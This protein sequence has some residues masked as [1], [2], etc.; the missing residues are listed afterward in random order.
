MTTETLAIPP[1]PPLQL[2][3]EHLRILVS[4]LQEHALYMLDPD[5]IVISW[6]GGAQSIKHYR[7]EEVIGQHFAIFFTAEDRA[8][9]HPQ[10]ALGI[11]R[12]GGIME[13]EGWRVRKDGS[14]FW[15]SV[16]ITAMHSPGGELIGFAK[17]TRD[18]SAR[19]TAEL[20]F[21]VALDRT[22]AAERLLLLKNSELEL[23]VLERT[24]ELT[25]RSQD[26]LRSNTELRQFN[27]IASHDLQEPLRLI[28]AFCGKLRESDQQ[29]FT[30]D[31]LEDMRQVIHAAGRMKQLILDLLAFGSVQNRTGT[32]IMMSLDKAVIEARANLR[33][34]ID[35]SQA[36]IES[37]DLPTLTADYR[38]MV[39]LLQNLIGNALKYR[40]D[41]TPLITIQ[42][43][44]HESSWEISVTDNGI[45]I[46]ER[47]RKRVF[48]L[49]KRLHRSDR[50]PGTGL[51]LALCKLIVDLHHGAIRIETPASGMGTSFV[52]TLPDR[53]LDE[54]SIHS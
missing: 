4:S 17:V 35:E 50:Y 18:I 28:S 20:L 21:Q 52:V 40:G 1:T 38:L 43:R 42:G 15:A 5:G 25:I 48:E 33:V 32:F 14:R 8:A 26:L 19:H 7:A 22:E 10:R 47:H 37:S 3:V 51:G 53:R 49:F 2:S 23:R 12:A 54:A 45:G 13:E 44:R 6:N 30:P 9:G 39:Q 46:A 11:A 41:R 29:Q 36:M 31:T 34:A 24:H 27:Y 16:V